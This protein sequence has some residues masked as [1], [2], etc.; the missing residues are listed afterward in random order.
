[1][2]LEPGEMRIAQRSAQ[3]FIARMIRDRA[4]LG[5]ADPIPSPTQVRIA[6]Q[7]K[8]AHWDNMTPQA[9]RGVAE[10]AVAAAKAARDIERR[11]AQTLAPERHA[12]DPTIGRDQE[13]YR[14]VVL[15]RTGTGPGDWVTRTAEVRSDTP[16][17]RTEIEERV[18]SH[19]DYYESA[20]PSTRAAIA[21]LPAA[22]ALHVE[23][24]SAFRR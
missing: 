5:S 24:V 22:S 12:R 9:A 18:A 7:R 19:I 20:R 11:P 3:G 4:A 1:M 14:Y 13:R 8:Y 17:S 15:V 2:P 21:R 10:S 6:L 23:V 16:L